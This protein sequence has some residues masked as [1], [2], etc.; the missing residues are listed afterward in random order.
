[1][2]KYCLLLMITLSSGIIAFGQSKTT[3]E[4]IIKTTEK[5]SGENVEFEGLVARYVA[6]NTVTTSFFE[7]QGYYG[8]RILI[9]TSASKPGVNDFYRLTGVLTITRQ[10]TP[11][12][13]ETKR[14]LIPRPD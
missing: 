9:T 7:M 6:G 14:E 11:L 3:I 12:V 1:M 2:K 8:A 10:G 13:V 5:Y 4:S